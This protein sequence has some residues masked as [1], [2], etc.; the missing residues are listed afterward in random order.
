M[1]KHLIIK[2]LFVCGLFISGHQVGW[3]QQNYGKLVLKF[4]YTANGKALLMG[5]GNHTNVFS[6]N[7]TITRLK[8][9]ISNI[10]LSGNEVFLVDAS[11]EDSIQVQA[12]PGV[13]SKL[14]FTLGVDSILNCSGAQEGA[15]DPLNGMFWTWN[16]GYVFFKLE[17]YSPASTADLHRIEHHIGGYQGIHK[18]SRKIELFF[19]EPLLINET[20]FNTIYLQMDLD[21]YWQGKNDII[22][23]ANALIM[24]PGEGAKRVADNFA[25][26]FSIISIK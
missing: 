5:D 11:K 26:M 18:A 4:N 12:F 25:G 15:L 2:F 9:Y 20:D 21:K 24:I 22:I 23:A 3:A 1:S 10:S 17:G 19:K 13:Y 14:V 8:Y 7:Y 6:E 16:S